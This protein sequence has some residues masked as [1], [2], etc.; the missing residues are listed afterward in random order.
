MAD[1]KWKREMDKIRHEFRW[2][3]DIANAEED[4]IESRIV[5]SESR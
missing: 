1:D 2:K 4:S 3:I 5:N